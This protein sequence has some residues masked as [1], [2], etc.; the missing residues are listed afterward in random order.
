MPIDRPTLEG[1]IKASGGAQQPDDQV[2]GLLAKLRALEATGRYGAL[3]KTLVKTNNKS[4]F[5]AFLLEAT[6]AHQFETVNMPLEYE[7]KQTPDHPSSIDF[8]L[9]SKSGDKVFFELQLQQQDQPTANVIARQLAAGPVYAVEKNGDSEVGEIFRLQSTILRKVQKADGTPIKFLQDGHGI[10]N[11]VVVCISDIL[12]GTSDVYDCILSMYGDSE[13]PEHCRRGVFGLFQD[14][15]AGDTEEFQSRAAKYA[16]IRR[17][18]HGV[19]FIF[20]PDGSGVLDYRLQQFM[21][22]NRNLLSKTQA[23]LLMEQIAVA[24]PVKA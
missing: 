12:L 15:K 11:I 8:K 22:W 16:H 24:L 20:R 7:V 23:S 9:A 3:F 1:A 17:T 4:N 6:F 13:V 19:L 5:L 14:P 10:V 18:L 2:D 21:V